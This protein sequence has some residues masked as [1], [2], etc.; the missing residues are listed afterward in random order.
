MEVWIG[1]DGERHGPYKEVDI[2]Q[3]LLRIWSSN[4]APR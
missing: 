4:P 1:R 2:R 3:W